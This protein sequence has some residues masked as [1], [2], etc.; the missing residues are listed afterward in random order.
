MDLFL[1]SALLKRI[2]VISTGAP[3][4]AFARKHGGEAEKS[5]R[6]PD[7]SIRL[8]STFQT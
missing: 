2:S 4:L 6:K 5:I 7:F 3:V 8:G 1:Q